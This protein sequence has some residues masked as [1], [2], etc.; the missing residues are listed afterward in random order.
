LGKVTGVRHKSVLTDP[1]MVV[2]KNQAPCKVRTAYIVDCV[3]YD[4]RV[5]RINDADIDTLAAALLERMYR[6]KIG[7]TFVEPPQP[8]QKVVDET[9][10]VFRNK[11]LKKTRFSPLISPEQFTQMYQGRKRTI[12]ENA[13]PEYYATGVQKKHAVSCAFVKCEKVNPEKAPRCIQPRHPV[14]NIG[15]GRYLKPNEH[16]LYEAIA[17][18]FDDDLPV[19]MK[20]MNVRQTAEVIVEKWSSIGECAAIGLDATKFDMHVSTSMLKWEHSIYKILHSQDPEL[21]RLLAMQVKNKGVGYC[22]DGRLTYK[23]EGRRFSGD[24]NTAL[25]NCIIM[26]AMVWEYCRQKGIKV[27]FI[28]NGDDC[29]V[30]MAREDVDHFNEGLDAWFIELGF[31]MTVEAPVYEL[32]KLEF[33]QM[34]PIQTA[35]GWVMVRNFEV[36][37]EKDSLSII[38]LDTEKAFRKWLY[39]VGECGLA[40]T[41][42]VPVFQELYS[43]YMRNGVPSNIDKHPSLATGARMMA[44]GLE[45]KRALVAPI[46][47]VTF[48]EAWGVTPDEQVALEQLYAQQVLPYGVRAV[49]T[50]LEITTLPL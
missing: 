10:R 4:M 28:N 22:D 33:C 30:F 47:R 46:A 21:K 27:R 25:G 42:G 29:V 36:A 31:R 20:G 5:L 23:V 24:M 34:H 14:Y 8:E 39:A 40:L 7:G 50:L 18:V 38:P 2:T 17:R 6:C 13:L 9:L 49:D 35:E 45:S 1:R 19:V 11:L 26:S 32:S 41:S 48:F 15:L 37:R 16:H 43:M 3:S 12:Y 44:R